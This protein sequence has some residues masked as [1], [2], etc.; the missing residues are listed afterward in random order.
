MSITHFK[1]TDSAVLD[2]SNPVAVPLGDPVA[3][4]SVT[5]V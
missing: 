5:C 4:T 3:L 2:S 1:N